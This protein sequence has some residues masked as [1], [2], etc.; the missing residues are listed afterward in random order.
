MRIS[1][2]SCHMTCSAPHPMTAP[3]R[4]VGRL[5]DEELLHG[6]VVADPLL[7]QQDPLLRVGLDEVTDG[8]HVGGQRR[9]DA[10]VGRHVE[11]V[12]GS[13]RVSGAAWTAD[14]AN[15]RSSARP[16]RVPRRSSRSTPASDRALR[17]VEAAPPSSRPARARS[18]AASAPARAPSSSGRAGRHAGHAGPPAARRGRAAPGRRRPGWGCRPRRRSSPPRSRRLSGPNSSSTTRI[19]ACDGVSPVAASNRAKARLPSRCAARIR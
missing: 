17:R 6:L 5:G 13:G 10:D 2:R 8:A 19:S 3:G 16:S 1:A 9:A 14:A 18:P 7:G 12:D 15:L 11:R 4:L